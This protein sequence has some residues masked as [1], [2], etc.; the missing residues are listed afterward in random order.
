MVS[1]IFTTAFWVFWWLFGFN[2]I[3]NPKESFSFYLGG[4]WTLFG[5]KTCVYLEEK[6][7]EKE[8]PTNESD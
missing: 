4:I 7:E 3:G 2:I 5:Y 6:L 1:L 8:T